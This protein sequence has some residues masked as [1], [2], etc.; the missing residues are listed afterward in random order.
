MTSQNIL[1]DVNWNLARIYLLEI[2]LQIRLIILWAPYFGFYILVDNFRSF[3]QNEHTLPW[4]IWLHD[5]SELD[6]TEIF[7]CVFLNNIL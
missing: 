6:D 2:I 5:A 1:W 4:D 3:G 7:D